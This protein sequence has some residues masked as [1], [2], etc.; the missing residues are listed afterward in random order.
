M[1]M[2]AVEN[3]AYAIVSGTIGILIAFL[4]AVSGFRKDRVAMDSARALAVS[5]QRA[6]DLAT[7]TAGVEMLKSDNSTLRAEVDALRT[8]VRA[9]ERRDRKKDRRIDRLVDALQRAGVQYD[10]DTD[11]NAE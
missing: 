6:Q 2:L 10:D 1:T 11:D 5:Q 9:C 7:L 3:G 8:E 4:A